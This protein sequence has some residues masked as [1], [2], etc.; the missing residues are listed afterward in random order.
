MR[1]HFS[2]SHVPGKHLVIADALSRAPVS[3]PATEDVLLQQV[4]DAYYVQMIIQSIPATEKRL[5][6]IKTHQDRD[7]VCQK[8][9]H[10][11]KVGWPH[12]SLL[13]GPVKKYL[14]VS[15]QLSIEEGL[16][17][18]GSQIVIP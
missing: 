5:Q 7:E 15:S 18:R 2:I 16:L 6:E 9:I 4:A 14:P 17:M 1:F 12:R 11:C 8:L 13:K 10:F 3:Y